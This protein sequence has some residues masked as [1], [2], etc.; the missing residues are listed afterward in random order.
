MIEADDIAQAMK[1]IVAH[2]GVASST[3]KTAP[4]DS[5]SWAARYAAGV[6]RPLT[7]ASW[8]AKAE[9]DAVLALWNGY[10]DDAAARMG[11]FLRRT[12]RRMLIVGPQH[13]TLRG[14]NGGTAEVAASYDDPIVLSPSAIIVAPGGIWPK[15]T[16]ARQPVQP[17]WVEA[18]EPGRQHRL[19]WLIEQYRSGRMLVAVGFDSLYVGQRS[20]FRGLRFASTD[21]ASALWFGAEGAEYSPA[22]A[23]LSDSNL[24]TAKP[25]VGIDDAICLLEQY[26]ASARRRRT[27]PTAWTSPAS[28]AAEA[29]P[30]QSPGQ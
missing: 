20:L 21:Q 24:L 11:Q 19:D 9:Y 17:Q 22:K 29:A 2:A 16:K 8:S 6:A 13:G 4:P 15:K 1:Q 27:S 5:G 23:M 25:L 7:G 12:R 28:E 30:G 10:D 3:P 18:G 14:L 26:S